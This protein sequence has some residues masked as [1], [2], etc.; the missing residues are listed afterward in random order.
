MSITITINNNVKYLR[1]NAPESITR[2]YLDP[3]D[4]YDQQ[5]LQYYPEGYREYFPFEMNLANANFGDL[6]RSLELEFDYSGELSADV[7]IKALEENFSV[8]KLVANGFT[9]GNYIEIGRSREQVTSYY[10]RL[11][12]LAR[13]ALKRGENIVWS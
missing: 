5:M 9:E 2:E 7:V 6:W 11:N 1:E 4:I 13:E 10:W 12:Q 8:K 3:N